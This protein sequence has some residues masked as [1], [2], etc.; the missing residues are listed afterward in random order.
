MAASKKSKLLEKAKLTAP[1]PN[2]ARLAG[3]A[4]EKIGYRI[5]PIS[6]YTPEANWIDEITDVLKQ[7]GNPK[8]NRSM[9]VR[10]AIHLLQE[11]LGDRQSDEILQFFISRHKQLS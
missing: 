6:L 11:S 1:Q 8:A 10:E 4:R 3:N 5:V 2:P 7:S 9:V